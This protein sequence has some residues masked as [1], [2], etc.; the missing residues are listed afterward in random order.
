MSQTAVRVAALLFSLLLAGQGFFA[1]PLWLSW[2]VFLAAY[3]LV[4]GAVAA[5]CAWRAQLR[6]AASFSVASVVSVPQAELAIDCGASFVLVCG[7]EPCRDLLGARLGARLARC[8]GRVAFFSSGHFKRAA[9]FLPSPNPHAPRFGDAGVSEADLVVLQ[10]VM[11]L[12]REALDTLSNF[13]TF[14]RATRPSLLGRPSCAPPVDVVVV[15]SE[16]HVPRVR[17]LAWPMLGAQGLSFL[18]CPC[19]GDNESEA[20]WRLWR[21]TLR[22]GLWLALGFEGGALAA[23]R[24]RD[25]RLEREALRCQKDKD[26]KAA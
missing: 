15:T 24:H 5:A 3:V 13:T 6:R 1:R 7:G 18:I 8:G 26:A 25:R 9:D 23:L 12:D 2:V 11:V 20:R 17:A 14:L 10:K 22:A 19:P 4:V 21:D 16:Y